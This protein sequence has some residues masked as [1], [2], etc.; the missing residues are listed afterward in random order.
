[1]LGHDYDSIPHCHKPSYVVGNP[2][3]LAQYLNFSKITSRIPSMGR[4]VAVVTMNVNTCKHF[5]RRDACPSFT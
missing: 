5:T 1:M 4:L 2:L 3:S